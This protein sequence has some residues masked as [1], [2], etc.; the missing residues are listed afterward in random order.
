VVR[1]G[2]L[3]RKGQAMNEIVWNSAIEIADMGE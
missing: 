1:Y 3:V 2:Q